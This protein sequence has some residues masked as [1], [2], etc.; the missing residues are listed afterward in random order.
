[1]ALWASHAYLFFQ[2]HPFH[3]VQPSYVCLR[4]KTTT[5][6]S[7]YASFILKNNYER[8]PRVWKLVTADSGSTRE[9]MEGT[10]LISL[11]SSRRRTQNC[12]IWMTIS[13]IL[14]LHGVHISTYIF[15]IDDR[16]RSCLWIA[17]ASLL[18][19]LRYADSDEGAFVGA[20]KSVSARRIIGLWSFGRL[21]VG[22]TDGTARS[23]RRCTL[24]IHEDTELWCVL[25][26]VV[27][28]F[29][30]VSSPSR[31]DCMS[32][33]TYTKIVDRVCN[34]R[35]YIF[36]LLLHGLSAFLHFRYESY[37]CSMFML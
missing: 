17:G 28:A 18:S 26:A 6:T 15:A 11:A 37:V 22:T 10:R 32:L 30:A 8:E 24:L 33:T 3:I 19:Q 31:M 9:R 16:L 1:M 34:L 5:W 25:D 2:P 23:K 12:L 13:T 27:D 20:G 14:P 29:E 21:E 36:S 4:C 35:H 7:F